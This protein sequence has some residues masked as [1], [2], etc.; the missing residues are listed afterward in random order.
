[1]GRSDRRVGFLAVAC[2]V[3]LMLLVPYVSAT[4]SGTA[5]PN[6]RDP[7][8]AD[9]P[10]AIASLKN[11]IAYV[12]EDQDVRMSGTI[13]Y[14]DTI[15]D[16]A[17]ITDLQDIHDDYLV[18]ASS[19]P[20]M[21]TYAEIAAARE[22]L[23]AKTKLFSEETKARMVMFNGTTD[24]MRAGLRSYENETGNAP[25]GNGSPHWLANE[26][27]RLTLFNR[28]SMDRLRTIRSLDRQGINTTVIRNLS[29]QIDALRP[30]LKEALTNQ[31]AE[32]MESVNTAIRDLTHAFRADV[33]SVRAS[34]E[35]EMKRDAMMAM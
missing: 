8:D 9:R 7:N 6:S 25:S 2:C 34:R 28:A 21:H 35:I 31:S 4:V 16:G 30:G 17:G 27:A 5:I 3:I 18:I 12:S 20:V 23:S 13:R 15:S 11:H 24:D 14:I 19:I 22:D 10:E 33:A 32:A 29:E 26:S 1:M